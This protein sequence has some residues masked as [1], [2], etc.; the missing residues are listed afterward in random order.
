[1]PDRSGEFA[2]LITELATMSPRMMLLCGIVELRSRLSSVLVPLQIIDLGGA[3]SVPDEMVET[4]RRAI[5]AVLEASDLCGV[6]IGGV[7][8]LPTDDPQIDSVEGK[9]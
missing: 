2:D 4:I 1:M 6:L 5:M 7:D 9:E 3:G 8:R